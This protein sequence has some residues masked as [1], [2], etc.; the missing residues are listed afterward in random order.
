MDFHFWG[1]RVELQFLRECVG[2]GAEGVF[3]RGIGSVADYGIKG[4]KG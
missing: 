3:A 1:L 2:E 4:Y